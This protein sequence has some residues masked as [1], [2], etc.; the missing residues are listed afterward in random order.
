MADLDPQ[1]VER[2]VQGLS[3]IALYTA[4]G[5]RVEQDVYTGA[6]FGIMYEHHEIHEGNHY[7]VT[8]IDTDVDTGAPK[9]WLVR[10]PDTAV[11]IHFSGGY[12]ADAA[13]LWEFYENPTVNNVGSA[14]TVHNNDFNS[15]NTATCFLYYDAVSGGD[16]TLKWKQKTGASGTPLESSGGSGRREREFILK[17]NEDYFIKFTLDADDTLAGIEINFYETTPKS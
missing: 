1:D 14:L 13:G 17:Q 12:Y 9:Y 16:G 7:E 5:R 10:T 8:D 2:Q 4:D 15:A 6:L 11:R 3:G